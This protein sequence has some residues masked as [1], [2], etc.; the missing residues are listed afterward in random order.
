MNVFNNN[1]YKLKLQDDM[2]VLMIPI[3]IFH[4]Q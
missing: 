2:D 3:V 1:K 4:N